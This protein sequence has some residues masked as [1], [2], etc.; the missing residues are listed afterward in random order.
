MKVP[1]DFWG[2][3]WARSKYPDN[4][5]E[6]TFNARIIKHV[7][8]ENG[9]L[10]GVQACH[11][12]DQDHII[13]D[14]ELFNDYLRRKLVTG[15]ISIYIDNQH[16]KQTS[17]LSIM[18]LRL[19]F[20]HFILPAFFVNFSEPPATKSDPLRSKSGPSRINSGVGKQS[21]GRPSKKSQRG[22]PKP[23]GNPSTT[24]VNRP[25]TRS[26]AA[27]PSPDASAHNFRASE[28]LLDGIIPHT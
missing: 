5:R 14:K 27:V 1:A 15:S 13:I 11:R 24:G 25:P 10:E 2:E 8:A 21:R 26:Q 6:K 17:S 18:T 22:Q 16:P 4:W 7:P 23:S 20:S 9:E 12:V 3:E 28:V 19:F